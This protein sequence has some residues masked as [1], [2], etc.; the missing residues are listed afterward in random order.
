MCIEKYRYLIFELTRRE[1]LNGT[2]F[3][4]GQ[5]V[6]H[7]DEVAQLF[8]PTI[9]CLAQNLAIKSGISDLGL[10][11]SIQYQNNRFPIQIEFSKD[12]FVFIA[13]F[14]LEVFEAIVCPASDDL[15]AVYVLAAQTT[16]ALFALEPPPHDH[17][18]GA[19]G[20]KYNE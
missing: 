7:A 1:I 12:V 15:S 16:T 18:L 4:Y 11:V 8:T 10:N 13:P 9:L 17:V 14:V 20:V 2:T 3:Q 5:G 19:I 6:L